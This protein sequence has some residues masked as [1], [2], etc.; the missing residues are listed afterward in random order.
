MLDMSWGEVMLIGG[1]A[2][3]VI[4][5]KDLP[6]ALRTLGQITT[7]VRRMAG[8]FQHQFNEAIREAELDEIK[9]DVADVKRQAE[10][11]KP[12]FNPVDTIRNELKSVVEGRARAGEA[13]PDLMQSTAPAAIAGASDAA[14]ER[15]AQGGSY[16]VPRPT[17]L[18][19]VVQPEMTDV[20][21]PHAQPGDPEPGAPKKSDGQPS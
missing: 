19:D 14:T 6:K 5:P 9:R 20:M 13:K 2:L 18:S 7:K 16:D 3:I 11:F 1:V 8:E 10:S 4:G 15:L 21:R 17:E 12:S